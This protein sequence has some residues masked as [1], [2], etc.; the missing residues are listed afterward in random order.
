MNITQAEQY[1]NLNCDPVPI[2]GDYQSELYTSS[3]PEI[4]LSSVLKENMQGQNVLKIEIP[5]TNKS[6]EDIHYGFQ[7][8]INI[9]KEDYISLYW[10]GN[11]SG[12]HIS[13]RFET[14]DWRNQY[15]YVF[16]DSWSGWARLIIPQLFQSTHWIAIM[17]LT[18]LQLI[19]YSMDHLTAETFFIWIESRRTKV[20]CFSVYPPE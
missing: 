17:G 13:L 11:D 20:N 19:L 9:S 15:E 14:G 4:S 16:V 2:S 1:Y 8:A 7:S 10:Y 6:G 18:L 5:P 12:S 3:D